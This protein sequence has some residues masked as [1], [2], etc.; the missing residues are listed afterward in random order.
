MLTYLSEGEMEK[1]ADLMHEDKT[2]VSGLDQISQYL[3]GRKINKLV[4][5]SVNMQTVKGNQGSSKTENATLQLTLDDG[6]SVYLSVMFFEDQKD[7][8]F[9]SFQLVLGAI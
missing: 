5:Q 2:D 8:G 4:T 1:A 9:L 6:E 7:Q 3:D